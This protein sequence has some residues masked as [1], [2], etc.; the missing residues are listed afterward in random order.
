MTATAW[1][2]LAI[3]AEVCATITLKATEN[4]SRPLPSAV[5]VIGYAA[6]FYFLSL[7]LRTMP[8]GVAYAIWSGVGMVLVAVLA[9]I[10]YEQEL[11]ATSIAGIALI[12]AGAA[13][14]HL[15]TPAG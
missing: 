4:F 2:A 14:L 7:A 1:L 3:V 13:I 12:I 10:I 8:I 9:W 6:A 15:R 11:E 5:V